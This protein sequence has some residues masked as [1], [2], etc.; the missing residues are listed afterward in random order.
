MSPALHIVEPTLNSY[1]GHCHSFVAACAEAARG[2]P[3]VIW[4]GRQGAGVWQ[5]AGR[6]EPYFRRPLR[7]VQTYILLRR[8]LREPGPILIATAGTADLLAADLAA[9][10][11]IPPGKLFFYFHWLGGK[12][13]RAKRLARLAAR[14]PQVEIL[15]P[16]ASV[17]DFFAQLGFR[18]QVVPYPVA[19][20][21][22]AASPG[23]GA[24]FRHLLVAGAARLDKG[25]DR[26]ADLVV[27]LARRGASLPLCVQASPT[28]RGRHDA[29]IEREIGRLRGAAYAGLTLCTETLAPAAYA[30]AFRG[31]I[32]LQPYASGD[33]HDRVSGV[34]LDALNAGCPVVVSAGTWMARV[35]DS[36][37][38]GV[39][40]TD[41]SPAGLIHAIDAIL[42]DYP[43]YAARAAAAGRILQTQ[44][45]AGRV[46]DAIFGP[47]P[48]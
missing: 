23:A 24:A 9:Q 37:G 25:F 43:G 36:H 42:A 32:A 33:F 19:R 22:A 26:V 16:T 34:T 11:E 20:Q 44:H 35:I 7:R 4:A 29:A 21:A 48:G 5:G 15:A 41:L 2:A 39:A 8:L 38:A 47:A 31:A 1:A 17:A 10:G 6:I 18:S 3:P 30:D 27:E 12:A 13:S 40:T 45:S 14:Q 46:I 28:H